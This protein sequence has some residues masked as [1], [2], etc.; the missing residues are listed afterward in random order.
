[1][2][3][4]LILTFLSAASI[5]LS[6]QIKVADK[7]Y[8][9]AFLKS[10]T[11]IVL[12]ENPFS[13]LNSFLDSSMKV[14]W[15]ITP[16]EVIT[17]EQFEQK[18]GDPN[19]SFM[20]VSLAQISKTG[21]FDYLVLNLSMGDASKNLNALHDLCVIP[22][23]YEEVDEETYEYKFPAFIRF[24]QYF[25]KYSEQNQGKDIK[26][27]VKENQVELKDYELWFTSEELADDANS[28][29]K[30]AKVYPYAV[31]LV[32]QT[33]IQ[34]AIYEANPAVAFLHKV[35][36]EGTAG[37]GALCLKLILTAKEGK[38]LYFDY[39]KISSSKPDAF[40]LDDFK[41]LTK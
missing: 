28:I 11:Y 36:P 25:I 29:A 39:H 30:I 6:A 23:A 32:A 22:L 18:M 1:M 14:M 21:S 20:Y 12:D 9:D 13:V 19:S 10:K 7:A 31:K 26:Q 34:K 37:D 2:K 33:D 15:N 24:A 4:L 3:K 38:P 17:N 40:L 5:C 8:I 41:N 35:G 16:Y 27:V